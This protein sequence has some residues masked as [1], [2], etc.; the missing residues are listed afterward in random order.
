MKHYLYLISGLLAVFF[1]VA[2][3]WGAAKVSYINV[4]GTTLV[5]SIAEDKTVASPAC[6]LTD[7]AEKWALDLTSQ[8]GISSYNI[9]L[10]AVANNLKIAVESA[11]DCG[12][13]DG[14]E[15]PKSVALAQ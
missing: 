12:A 1:C 15:R 6:V 3:A 8:A 13:R 5:F 11:G 7:D 9:L 10:T 4:D 2:P 14:I